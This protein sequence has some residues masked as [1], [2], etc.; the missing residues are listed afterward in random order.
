M[1]E[2]DNEYIYTEQQLIDLCR[3]WQKI[4]KLE[5]WEIALHV[6]RARDFAVEGRCGECSWVLST[7]LATMRII[8]PVDYPE[9]PFKQDMELILVHE[10]LHLHMCPF[11]LTKQDS[12]EETMMERAIDHIAKALV[13]LKREKA[14]N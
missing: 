4:L 3:E 11:D 13:N 2:S 10:L 14:A 5:H 1:Y 6:S 9:S 7:A 8:D 12:L